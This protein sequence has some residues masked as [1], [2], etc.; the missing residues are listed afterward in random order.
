MYIEAVYARNIV[1][2]FYANFIPLDLTPP[3]QNKYINDCK[4]SAKEKSIYLYKEIEVGEKNAVFACIQ[5]H[6]VDEWPFVDTMQRYSQAS[7]MA[8]ELS[9][10]TMLKL[11][12]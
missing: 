11:P 3:V 2:E 9:L 5:P 1:C 7:R 10:W 4:N 8:L 6:H 12:F